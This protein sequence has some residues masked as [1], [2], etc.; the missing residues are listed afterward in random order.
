[1]AVLDNAVGA[2]ARVLLRLDR[3]D[4][5]EVVVASLLPHLP[6]KDD[7]QEDWVVYESLAYA[8]DF[9]S[10]ETRSKLA[11]KAAAALA[12]SRVES[13]LARAALERIMRG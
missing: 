11:G 9:L 2:V 1:M 4:M 6:L 13:R 5:I 12:D 7:H 8:S 10:E 3:A